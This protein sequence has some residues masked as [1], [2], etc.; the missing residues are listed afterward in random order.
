[1]TTRMAMQLKHLSKL[2]DNS[3]VAKSTN[4]M[5]KQ[6]HFKIIPI[7]CNSIELQSFLDCLKKSTRSEETDKFL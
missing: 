1:M 7:I 2:T 6:F 4:I 3:D 5:L